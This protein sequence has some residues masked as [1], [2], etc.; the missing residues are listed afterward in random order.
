MWA[1]LVSATGSILGEKLYGHGLWASVDEARGKMYTCKVCGRK[2][3]SIKAL[4]GRASIPLIFID[5]LK[6]I[7]QVNTA[8]SYSKYIRQQ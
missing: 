6:L 2:F 4:G 7:S 3:K 1:W 5:S 8:S